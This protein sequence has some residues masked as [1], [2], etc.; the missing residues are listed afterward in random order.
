L[1]LLSRDWSLR[2]TVTSSSQ[3]S[4]PASRTLTRGWALCRAG[5]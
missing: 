2:S 5:G 4:A 1:P 3:A